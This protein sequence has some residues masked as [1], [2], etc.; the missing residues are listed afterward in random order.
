[1]ITYHQRRSNLAFWSGRFKAGM[2][3]LFE[4]ADR[5]TALGDSGQIWAAYNRIMNR[6]HYLEMDDSTLYYNTKANQYAD[7]FQKIDF[8]LVSA[9]LDNTIVPGIRPEFE[10][11][12]RNLRSRLP[13]EM[14]G[15]ADEVQNLERVRNLRSR[16]P[17]EM[18]GL[19]DEV[20][21]LLNALGNS[22][23]AAIIGSYK[24]LMENYTQENTENR[25]I[26]GRLLVLSGKYEE[27]MTYLKQIC[28]GDDETTQARYY[29]RGLYY[30]GIAEEAL[31]NREAATE[32]YRELLKLWGDADIE[33]EIVTDART[34]LARLTS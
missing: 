23:T 13:E 30:I 26:V 28:T 19:A 33:L 22:D 32:A 10:E 25:E 27:G 12:V 18:W 8:Y 6:Y 3:E 20:Q 21:N 17:E 2:N 15:L 24:S 11:R 7:Q 9:Q 34:R 4:S 5:A 16:L 31:G 1:M 14:W 29:M